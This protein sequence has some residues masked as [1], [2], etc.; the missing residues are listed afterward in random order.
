VIGSIRRECLDHVI[1]LNER[2]LHFIL[3][4]CFVSVAEAIS[5]RLTADRG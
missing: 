1:A 2:H 5:G 3:T 4:E